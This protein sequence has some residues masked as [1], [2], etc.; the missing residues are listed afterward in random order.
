MPYLVPI[1]IGIFNH[2]LSPPR[3][4]INNRTIDGR[5]HIR[6]LFVDCVLAVYEI[7]IHAFMGFALSLPWRSK[8]LTM[9]TIMSDAWLIAATGGQNV[10]HNVLKTHT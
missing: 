5:T 2:N 3:I 6:K 1:A 8:A 10:L 7:D 4:N 9:L